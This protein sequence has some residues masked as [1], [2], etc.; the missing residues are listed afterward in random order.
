MRRFLITA[1]ALSSALVANAVSA[2]APAEA[3]DQ[4]RTC[5]VNNVA[6]LGNRVHV[7]CDPIAGGGLLPPPIYFAVEINNP[8]ADKLIILASQA[9]LGNR[10]LSLTY[11]GTP[12]ANPPGCAVNDCRRLTSAWL[13]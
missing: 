5:K 8:M 9:L 7:R 4:N 10:P 1:F 12:G 2:P 11:E 6:V 3:A 13:Q